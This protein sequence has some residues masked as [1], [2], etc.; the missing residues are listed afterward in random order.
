MFAWLDSVSP[1]DANRVVKEER[2]PGGKGVHVALAIAELGAQAELLGVWGGPTGAWIKDQCTNAGV[3]CHGPE[4]NEWSRT[5]ITLKSEDQYHDTE[6]LGTGPRLQTA[7]YEHLVATYKHL[8]PGF[9]HIC[10]SG[11]WPPGVATNAYANLIKIAREQGK[12]TILDASGQ[13]LLLALNEKPDVLH[14]NA[15]E[16][17]DLLQETDVRRCAIE[18]ARRCRYALVTAG[19]EGLYLA[20]AGE[21]IHA[22]CAIE[23]VHSTVGSGDCLVAGFTVALQ[24]RVSME[25]AARLAVACGAANCLRRDLG[26]LYRSDVEKLLPLVQIR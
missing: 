10:M 23:E 8:L 6:L 5:C 21:V 7:D 14:V 24:R 16:A 11:S 2:F 15:S 26:M 13:Q 12:V 22:H 3:I 4:V 25:D 20:H 17:R 1:G 9:G 19:A 18:L